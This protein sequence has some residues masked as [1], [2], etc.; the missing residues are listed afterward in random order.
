[1]PIIQSYLTICI[2]YSLKKRNVSRFEGIIA[3][4]MSLFSKIVM[5]VLLIP[6]LS[7]WIWE[8][9]TDFENLCR[10]TLHKIAKSCTQLKFKVDEAS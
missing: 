4:K 7:F 10:K 8:L 3:M 9:A 5:L 1:M 6:G 2:L